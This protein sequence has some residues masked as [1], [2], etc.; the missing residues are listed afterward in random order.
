M[1]RNNIYEDGSSSYLTLP[2]SN[3]SQ[4]V[5]LV[6]QLCLLLSP[7]PLRPPPELL[8]KFLLEGNNIATRCPRCVQGGG[9]GGHATEQRQVAQEADDMALEA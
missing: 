2:P 6:N 1:S 8:K 4:P 7:G 3:F 9:Q 5:S